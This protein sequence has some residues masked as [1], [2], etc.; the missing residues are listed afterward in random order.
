MPEARGLRNV[1]VV[2]ADD[3]RAD[4]LDG[5]PALSALAARSLR[6]GQHYSPQASCSPARTAMLTSRRPDATRVYDLYSYWRDVGG[7]FVSLPEL[8]A[9]P[10]PTLEHPLFH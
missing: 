7:N 10:G 6:L 9:P 5:A 4:A 3:M 2:S 8:C 1:L